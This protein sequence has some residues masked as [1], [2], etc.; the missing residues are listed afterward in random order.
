MTLKRMTCEEHFYLYPTEMPKE[1]EG[2]FIFYEQNDA[3]QNFLIDWH[4]EIQK[5]KCDEEGDNVA[6]SCRN[7]YKEKRAARLRTRLTGIFF[8]AAAVLLIISAG[9]GIQN[10]NQYDKIQEVGQAVSEVMEAEANAESVSTEYVADND[11]LNVEV[12]EQEPSY[13]SEYAVAEY[14]RIK[15]EYLEEDSESVEE[16]ISELVEETSTSG[17]EQYVPE[18]LSVEEETESVVETDIQDITEIK[19]ESNYEEE[20]EE[21]ETVTDMVEQNVEAVAD[22]YVTYEVSKGDTLYGICVRFYGNLSKAKEIC[23]L[24][25]IENKD[26]ILYGQKILLPE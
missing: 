7:Y 26:N 2:Y 21:I 8:V 18:A 19:E 11:Y 25:G 22:N 4:G 9:I 10:L 1:T 15:G 20:P 23:E 5:D 12:A 17:N 24:N 3:M 13:G 16:Q 6:E 14:N